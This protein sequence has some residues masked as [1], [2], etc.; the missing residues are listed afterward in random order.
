MD[1]VFETRACPQRPT[2]EGD[3]A[4]GGRSSGWVACDVRVGWSEGGKRSE[5]EW[6]CWSWRGQEEERQSG[7]SSK[8]VQNGSESTADR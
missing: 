7:E 6:E 4:H 1:G 2:G 8:A 5:R 3:E